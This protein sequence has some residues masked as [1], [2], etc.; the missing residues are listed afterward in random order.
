[1]RTLPSGLVSA[2]VGAALLASATAGASSP[3]PSS[4]QA[5][6][7]PPSAWMALSML[8]TSGT[9]GLGDAAVQPASPPENA[10]APEGYNVGGIPTPV[11]AFWVLTVAAMIYIATRDSSGHLRFV[12]NSPG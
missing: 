12:P 5:A 6:Q 9:V 7:T 1:M 4:S 10:P 11:I 2:V 3:A 8:N